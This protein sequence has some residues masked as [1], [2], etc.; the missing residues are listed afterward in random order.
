MPHIPTLE[1]RLTKMENEVAELKRQFI[2]STKKTNW[3]KR[4][5]GTFADRPEF[6]EVLRLGKEIRDAELEQYQE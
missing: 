5:E 4:V 6:D 3:I 2:L 1:E